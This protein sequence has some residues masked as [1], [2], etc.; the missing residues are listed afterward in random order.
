ME[1]ASAHDPDT[2]MYYIKQSIQFGAQKI[3]ARGVKLRLGDVNVSII[4]ICTTSIT[5]S[6]VTAG[7]VRPTVR[8]FAQNKI[9]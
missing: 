8:L 5:T 1:T 7:A 4:F 9:A 2:G 3:C 6:T